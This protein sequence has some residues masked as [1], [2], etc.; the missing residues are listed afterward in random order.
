MD[1]DLLNFFKIG[2]SFFVGGGVVAFVTILSEKVSAQIGAIVSALP[3][4]IT[5]AIFFQGLLLGPDVV[6]YEALPKAI[7]ML[8]LVGV[9]FIVFVLTVRYGLLISMLCASALWIICG[10]LLGGVAI[11]SWFIAL[12]VF[13]VLSLVIFL[14]FQF[15]AIEPLRSSYKKSITVLEIVL[16]FIFAG[17]VILASVLLSYIAGPVWG[18]IVSTFPSLAASTLIILYFSSGADFTKFFAKLV[19]VRAIVNCGAFIIAVYYVYPLLGVWLGTLVA[20]IAPVLTAILFY[21]F[22]KNRSQAVKNAA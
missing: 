10:L 3:V 6:A 11:Q 18:G 7:I 17:S 9:F 4:P 21:Y 2:L 20:Y 14:L 1:A 15:I 13:A 16:R 22:D 12:I 19:F 5:I 8:A